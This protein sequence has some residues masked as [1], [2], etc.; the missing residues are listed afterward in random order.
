MTQEERKKKGVTW[1]GWRVGSYNKYGAKALTD[2]AVR[3][4]TTCDNENFSSCSGDG[5]SAAHNA[6]HGAAFGSHVKD[7]SDVGGLF[8]LIVDEE[9]LS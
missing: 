6:R 9:R 8:G 3:S 1:K 2:P 4:L 7:Q 5:Y